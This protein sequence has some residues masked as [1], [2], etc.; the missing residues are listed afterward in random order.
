LALLCAAPIITLLIAYTDPLHHLIKS[1]IEIHS[2]PPFGELTYTFGVGVYVVML[3]FYA[4]I[5]MGLFLLIRAFLQ[6]H[7]IYRS[8]TMVVLIGMMFP[9][10]G[11]ILGLIGMNLG[12]HRDIAPLTL[13]LSNIFVAWGL[14]RLRLLDVIPIAHNKVL[15]GM[16]DALVVID[17]QHHVVDLNPAAR[18]VLGN[19]KAEVIGKPVTDVFSAWLDLGARL[20]GS[21][22]SYE[23]VRIIVNG[24]EKYF[25]FSLSPLNSRQGQSLG[26]LI[27]G[28]DVTLRKQIEDAEHQ[29]RVFAEA[30]V[31]ITKALN[32]TLNL[33][34]LLDSILENIEHVVPYKRAEIY[35]IRSE[36]LIV[37][38]TRSTEVDR[39]GSAV[40]LTVAIEDASIVKQGRT[41]RQPFLIEDTALLLHDPVLAKSYV[42]QYQWIRSYLGMPFYSGEKWLGFIALAHDV[43]GFIRRHS[44]HVYRHLPN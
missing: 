35:L 29:Q 11:S 41:S 26:Y 39:P 1:N 31:G 44:F 27:V 21:P 19:P 4:L 20:Q 32:S 9:V 18:A 2:A 15:E 16:P 40:G 5:L 23:K 17:N 22:A 3:Y 13:A 14:F 42:A 10:V 24:E 25:D 36:E 30:L 12:T 28:R 6:L 37:V 7:S 33:D 34:D 38:G 43:P 8:Q